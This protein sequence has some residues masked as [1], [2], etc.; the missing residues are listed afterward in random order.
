MK[1]IT[2]QVRSALEKHLTEKGPLDGSKM[3]RQ[4]NDEDLCELFAQYSK[5]SIFYLKRL[6]HMLLIYVIFP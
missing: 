6:S 1:P 4:M 5:C 3:I 2:T